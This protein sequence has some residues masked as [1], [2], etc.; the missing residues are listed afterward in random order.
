MHKRSAIIIILAL[1]A[2]LGIASAL[3]TRQIRLQ[4]PVVFL[5]EPQQVVSEDTTEAFRREGG[6]SL[7]EIAS[8]EVTDAS[9]VPTREELRKRYSASMIRVDADCVAH[10]G[11]VTA[12]PQ[13]TILVENDAAKKRDIV[14]GPRIYTIKA[15][16]YA[17]AAFTEDGTFSVTCDDGTA[18]AGRV[19]IKD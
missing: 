18:R 6:E 16:G 9:R 17:L 5:D 10:P 14:I 11:T 13:Q 8:A 2:V 19:I 1:V 7:E 4:S 12:A 3:V 15:D